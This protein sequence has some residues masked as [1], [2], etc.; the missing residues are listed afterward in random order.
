[1]NV[2]IANRGLSALKF[3]ISMKEWLSNDPHAYNIRL[4]GFVTPTDISCRYK[5]ITLLDTPI[6]TDNEKIYTDMDDIIKHCLKNGI[7]HL[8]PGWGYLSENEVFVQKLHDAGIVFLG[9]TF[10]NMHAIG[11]KISCNYVAEKLGVPVLLWSGDKQLTTLSEIEG[12]CDKIGYPVM[13]KAGN[14]GGG[15]G[16]RIV[17]ERRMCYEMWQEILQEVVEPM[18]YATKYIEN[19]SH[20][21]I[22]IIGDGT[23][24]INLHGRDCSTQRRNQ[25]L[26]EE[27]PIQ[28][29]ADIIERIQTYAENITRHIG[30]RGLATVEFIYDQDTKQVYILEVNPRIQVEHII[31]E[32]LFGI[33]LIKLLFQVSVGVKLSEIPELCNLNR[34]FTKHVLSVRINSENPYEDFRPTLGTIED[35]DITYNRNSWGYFSVG[36][37]SVISGSVDSQFGHLLAV[38]NTRDAAIRNMTNLIDILKIRGTIYNTASFLKQFIN[39][40]AFRE[41]KHTTRYLNDITNTRT[42]NRKYAVS[43]TVVLGMLYNAIFTSIGN[44]AL[45]LSQLERGHTYPLREQNKLHKSLI[46]FHNVLYEYE[47]IFEI[48]GDIAKTCILRYNGKNYKFKFKYD[49]SAM[50]IILNTVFYTVAHSFNDVNQIE[51]LIN[52]QKY[53][54]I[55]KIKDNQIISPVG[56]KVIECMFTNGDVVSEGITY[57]KIECMKMILSFKTEKSGVIHYTVRAGDV[58][59]SNQVIGK[60]ITDTETVRYETN[61]SL[62]NNY[63]DVLSDKI[64]YIVRKNAKLA[65]TTERIQSTEFDISDYPAFFSFEYTSLF[66][67]KMDVGTKGWVVRAANITFVLVANDLKYK[68]GVFSHKEDDFFYHCLNHART[69]KLPFVFIASNSGAEIRINENVKFAAKPFVRNDKLEYLY[70]DADEITKYENDVICEFR[71]EHGH[72]EIICVKNPGII[73]LDGS[74]LLVSEMA[75]ARL[76]I[77][78]ITFVVNRTVGVGAYLARLSER[79][80]QRSDSCILLTG[81]Q[82]INKVLGR[83]LYESNIQLGGTQIMANNGITHK[84]VDTTKD[85]LAYIKC[86]LSG[87]GNTN[88]IVPDLV[89]DMIDENTFLET[90]EDYARN[91]RTGR[92]LINGEKYGIVFAT[93]GISDKIQPC[94]P[95][96]IT[97]S[98]QTIKLSPNILYPETSYKIAK[99]IRDCNV[100]KI[101]LLIIAD[102]RGFSGGTRDMYDNVLDFGSMIVS[103][104]GCYEHPI[105][106][107]IPPG[108]QLRGGSMVV[109]SKSI[110]RHKI[111]FYVSRTAKINVLEANATMELKYKKL[112]QDKYS[113]IH[114]IH[115]AKLMETIAN[116]FVELND[117]IN[118]ECKILNQY[119]IIIDGVCEPIDMKRI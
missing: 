113:S 93:D 73:N 53:N 81:Y 31:S 26:I 86:L 84:V 97:T 44:H 9:P 71:P 50:T 25:K 4:F 82:A 55:R 41:N 99:T 88:T 3:I 15:K 36:G 33:N 66:T 12:W 83:D 72:Y 110:N 65:N 108:G 76:E 79:I 114:N 29:D 85:G 117:C 1:M 60:Y 52:Q 112:D 94:D 42:V 43:T 38:G 92:C 48:T 21:E 10:D 80:V 77:Q 24:V 118:P 27:C 49:N 56:G 2:C 28:K 8:F 89:R 35:I 30:Y 6:Y 19:A 18:I 58:I 107:Y 13:L 46:V 74:A 45:C 119:E 5:Y 70:L 37:N 22:Q 106:I 78:T 54:F 105:T 64:D 34:D 87:F 90:M 63:I 47:Y 59:S 14:S 39:Q 115:D 51:L 23:D 96:D 104:L 40:P 7:T 116:R 16:I 102:W 61:P 32:Q 68:N 67:H 69:N 75:K 100:E 111:K 109:F 98:N 91:V 57:I 62:L 11:N 95:A 101:K 103:E 17:R 20:L